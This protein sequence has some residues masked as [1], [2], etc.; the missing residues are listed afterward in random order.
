MFETIIAKGQFAA[1]DKVKQH[2]CPTGLIYVK[3]FPSKLRLPFM[4]ATFQ[5]PRHSCPRQP[6]LVPGD[7]TYPRRSSYARICSYGEAAHVSLDCDDLHDA[8]IVIDWKGG[9][10]GYRNGGYGERWRVCQD[11]DK[12]G[13]LYGRNWCNDPACLRY[14]VCTDSSANYPSLCQGRVDKAGA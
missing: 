4:P 3:F 11:A 14:C 5:C 13:I 2:P 12:L 10:V 8:V 1:K 9:L 7:G 6:V